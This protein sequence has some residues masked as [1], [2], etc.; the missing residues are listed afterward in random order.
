MKLFNLS[1][2][3]LVI[4]FLAAC[5]GNGNKTKSS[6]PSTRIE[7]N[8]T[9]LTV[10][11]LVTNGVVIAGADVVFTI[12]SQSFSAKTD[13]FGRYTIA[14]KI[15]PAE[16]GKPIKAVAKNAP[17][18]SKIEYASLLP[19]ANVLVQQAGSDQK[20][21][22]TENFNVNITPISTAEYA[23]ALQSEANIDTEEKLKN[24]L[25][26]VSAERKVNLAAVIK[27]ISD[28]ANYSLPDGFN[29]TLAVALDYRA[30]FNYISYVNSRDPN[31]IATTIESRA[32]D[33]NLVTG[34]RSP[35]VGEY[36]ISN[37][38]SLGSVVAFSLE[39]KEN[40]TGRI[41]VG[42]KINN[43]NYFDFSGSSNFKWKRIGN[44]MAL[45]LDTDLVSSSN[46]YG[47]P[48]PFSNG[49][50][51]G[52]CSQK[53]SDI[54]FSVIS[55]GSVSDLIALSYQLDTLKNSV[56]EVN[57]E[58]IQ[59]YF[60]LTKKNKLIAPSTDR[61]VGEWLDQQG[62]KIVYNSN[63]TGISTNL[64]DN[65]TKE[66][67]WKIA[68][69][70][71]YINFSNQQQI[72][73]LWVIKDFNVG[74]TFIEQ[75]SGLSEDY[76]IGNA[77]VKRQ[78]I[79]L[80]ED[81][82]VGRWAPAYPT[83]A[84]SQFVDIYSG[85]KYRSG[86]GP[87]SEWVMDSP[88]QYTVMLRDYFYSVRYS[89]T[90]SINIVAIDDGKYYESSCTLSISPSRCFLSVTTRNANFDGNVFWST[91]YGAIF[92]QPETNNTWDFIYLDL[93]TSLV[94]I[95]A[96]SIKQIDLNKFSY[97]SGGR[98][99]VLE[100]ISSAKDSIVVCEYETSKVCDRNKKFTL[101]AKPQPR[102]QITGRGNA[103]ISSISLGSRDVRYLGETFY[104]L[105]P[106]KGYS[107]Q[108]VTGCNGTLTGSQFKIPPV[109]AECTI[110]MNFVPSGA[111]S[112][113]STSKT[114]SSVASSYRPASIAWSSIGR[115]SSPTIISSASYSS[116]SSV[117][118]GP[119]NHYLKIDV[120]SSGTQTYMKQLATP[121]LKGLEAG[122]TYKISARLKASAPASVSFYVT[123]GPDHNWAPYPSDTNNP[124]TD[125]TT[126]WQTYEH[127]FV[128]DTTDPTTR[129]HLDYGL[130]GGYQ[131]YADDIS[132]KEV[133]TD[134]EQI[135][136]GNVL[137]DDQI[138]VEGAGLDALTY[139]YWYN[140]INDRLD[141][142][143]VT[144]ESEVILTS[145]TS[146]SSLNSSSASMASSSASS[147]VAGNKSLK[148]EV[149]NAGTN[150]WEPQY[151][152]F[153]TVGIV[154]G[155]NYTFSYRIKAS[156]ALS[157]YMQ[158]NVGADN[159]LA[160]LP[161][162]NFVEVSTDWKTYSTTFTAPLTDSSV[163][164]QVS[165]GANGTI[166][167]NDAY[168]LWIDDVSFTDEDGAN[169]QITNGTMVN[170]EDWL[171]E[172]QSSFGYAL[173][174]I[175]ENN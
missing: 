35:I 131:I 147:G 41:A 1:M 170:I 38:D 77:A 126:E 88:N 20:L 67:S 30:G 12:G 158:V 25:L 8:A 40:G 7:K 74:Y 31:L 72:I 14:L 87:Y 86:F 81:D 71:L 141:G 165:L 133:G 139:G 173:G 50:G 45:A 36:I 112:S 94:N 119:L 19:S 10:T 129:L 64:S 166:N 21:D 136:H 140:V 168:T 44:S 155:K 153:L 108:S 76:V 95:D 152:Q 164:F 163:Q 60:N 61:L 135:Y 172:N 33:S 66:F 54:E 146:S 149:S 132:V 148:I 75:N 2:L 27:I 22:V 46:K 127:T 97:V 83:E 145:S 171:Y 29:S 111:V 167:Y 59:K 156:R 82:I 17:N 161:A 52:Q 154:E 113:S 11:G 143:I 114:S 23:L 169:Q 4:L 115:S 55:E 157:T 24:A 68:D 48:S 73:E 109:T 9:N 122:K 150:H 110:N 78:N 162:D 53:I 89:W 105:S 85:G 99:L 3:S 144:V 65:S 51:I 91:F 92:Y 93:N 39:I 107:I 174:S 151:Q 121:L 96:K 69:N 106:E 128:A 13:E 175:V 18:L 28:N 32:F 118:D 49:C 58:K 116:S 104:N 159:G 100:L 16:R 117:V 98:S 124:G 120:S 80:S 123:L 130:L 62:K 34:L 84:D 37:S 103:F 56:S 137:S 42:K 57:S 125:I 79:T 43:N 134:D 63:G 138:L 6:E 102:V 101:V 15:N 90:R 47:I 26:D 5:G 160:G 142:V 70:H